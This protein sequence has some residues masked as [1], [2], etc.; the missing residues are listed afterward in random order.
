MKEELLKLNYANFEHY[1]IQKQIPVWI[2][3]MSEL[4]K[5]LCKWQRNYEKFEG[6]IPDNLL[7]NLK[8]E[9][10]DVQASLDQ[11]KK[12]I[13]FAIEEQEKFYLYKVNRTANNIKKEGK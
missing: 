4:T 10:I 8:E 1:G 2:E 11:I 7:F 6:D 13:N 3:E 5:E 12:A 9:T